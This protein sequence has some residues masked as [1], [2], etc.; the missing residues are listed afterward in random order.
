[1]GYAQGVTRLW[2]FL[3]TLLVAAGCGL[4]I[5][6]DRVDCSSDD[7]CADGFVCKSD[8]CVNS[9]KVEGADGGSTLAPDAG[10]AA[11]AGPPSDGGEVPGGDSGAPLD[12]GVSAESGPPPTL[13]AGQADSGPGTPTDS[14]SAFDAASP[15]SDASTMA[16]SGAIADSGISLEAGA[17]TDGGSLPEGGPSVTGSD[18]G[19]LFDAGLDAGV[20]DA[21]LYVDAGNAPDA[22]PCSTQTFPVDW[23]D[24]NW[25]YREKIRFNTLGIG[26]SG[27]VSNF[28]MRITLKPGQVSAEADGRDL[29]FADPTAPQVTLDYEIESAAGGVFEVWVKVPS[30][31]ANSVNDFIWAYWGNPSATDA[32]NVEGVWASGYLAVLHMN[33][34]NGTE[35]PDSA[36]TGVPAT[37]S[38]FATNAGGIVGNGVNFNGAATA[39]LP[40]LNGP[41]ASPPGDFPQDDGTVSLWFREDAASW[42]GNSRWIF[43]RYEGGSDASVRDKLTVGVYGSFGNLHAIAQNAGSPTSGD[44]DAYDVNTW[45]FAGIAFDNSPPETKAVVNYRTETETVLP[46]PFTPDEVEAILALDFDGIIDEVRIS[47]TQRSINWLRMERASTSGLVSVWGERPTPNKPPPPGIGLRA[48]DPAVLYLF[49][50]GSGTDVMDQSGRAN[51]ID[52]TIDDPGNVV[53]LP[54]GGL[55]IEQPTRLGET[56]AS[57]SNRLD[58]LCTSNNGFTVEAWLQPDNPT[59][60][61]QS[62]IVAFSLDAGERTFTLGQ[63]I[64]HEADKQGAHFSMRMRTDE[65][66]SNGE[67]NMVTGIRVPRTAGDLDMSAPLHVMAVYDGTITDSEVVRLYVDGQLSDEEPWP[68][69]CYEDNAND[70]GLILANEWVDDRPWLG[71]FFRVAIYDRPLSP[72]DVT[73]NYLAGP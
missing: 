68:G 33:T 59:L 21:A 26:N 18:S 16:D 71:T 29:R 15:A 48:N 4:F 65:T 63:D 49:D 44:N 53:W 22:G 37:L 43:D 66:N 8:I 47:S 34:I 58:D 67:T 69:T 56:L 31:D 73:Q 38:G 61:G 72:T 5:G 42:D 20:A 60:R 10:Q 12:A 17:I 64:G 51:P 1:L 11:D 9:D 36:D 46:D 7:D 41:N 52:L 30:L 55:R 14:G 6:T 24:A 50:E 25:C 39:S 45:H 2:F 54:G 13:D 27:S 28:P 23:L 70:F 40:H 35:L 62:R 57:S 32:Q 19:G 3:P